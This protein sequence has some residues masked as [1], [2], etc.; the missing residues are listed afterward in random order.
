MDAKNYKK[1]SPKKFDFRKKNFREKIHEKNC[2]CVHVFIV[3][4]KRYS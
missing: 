1:L 4:S 2:K 3:L